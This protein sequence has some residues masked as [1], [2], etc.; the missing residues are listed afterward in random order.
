MHLSDTSLNFVKN[1]SLLTLS[2][3][4]SLSVSSCG[5]QST[6]TASTDTEVQTDT[7]DEVAAYEADD[8]VTL[9]A[10]VE[11]LNIRD[12]PGSSGKSVARVQPSDPL[13][14]TGNM[15]ER[16]ETIVL[17]GAV[18]HEPWLE[19]TTP[20]GKE[21]WVYGGAVRTEDEDKGNAPIRA[22][23]FNFPYFGTYDLAEWKKSGTRYDG[24]G[25]VSTDVTIYIRGDLTLEVAESDSEYGYGR[26]YR[27]LNAKGETIKIRDFWYSSDMDLPQM[28]ETIRDYSSSPPREYTRT[29]EVGKHYNELNDRPLLVRGEWE[30]KNLPPIPDKVTV[31]NFTTQECGALQQGVSGCL[32]QFSSGDDPDGPIYFVSQRERTACMKI[33]GRMETFEGGYNSYRDDLRENIRL[34][35]WLSLEKD[36]TLR[37]FDDPV[38]LTDYDDI[39]NTLVDALLLMDVLPATVP[40]ENRGYQGMAIR[41]VRD[42]GTD[43]LAKAKERMQKGDRRIGRVEEYYHEDHNLF[44]KVRPFGEDLFQ[45]IIQLK[46]A[47][48]KILAEEK[49]S[50]RCRCGGSSG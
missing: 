38:T 49:V 29:Q 9:Y 37:L 41:E 4:L 23:R 47:N 10:W 8:D 45:G 11:D 50:G 1:L 39:V 15:S 48:G 14:F 31:Q 3:L 6:D 13:I 12:Q 32:C 5:Q 33:G 26:T 2:L 36:G 30:E 35:T 19:V 34:N 21:G 16:M 42:M 22:D 40:V 46:A 44:L 18:Y 25:D 17:R 43:A 7:G 24:E 28:T 27:L 20:D